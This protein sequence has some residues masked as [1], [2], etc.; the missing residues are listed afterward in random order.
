[1]IQLKLDSIF[2]KF[3]I[4][5]IRNVQGKEDLTALSGFRNGLNIIY[6]KSPRNPASLFPNLK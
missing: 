6:L 2:F 3:G 4:T 5:F 1:M